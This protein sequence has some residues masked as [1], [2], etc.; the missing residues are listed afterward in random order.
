MTNDDLAGMVETSDEWIRQR[1][2]IRERRRADPGT[3]TS[4]LAIAAGRAA[5]ERRGMDGSDLDLIIVATMT[6]DRPFPSTACVV[7]HGLGASSAWAFDVSAAC[8][9][10]VYAATVAAQFIE[11]G[12]HRRVLVIGAEVMSSVVDYT[13]RTTCVLFGDGAGAVLM[14]PSQ[15]ETGILSFCHEVDGAGAPF[16]CMPAGGSATPASH[17]T[18]EKGWH[19]LRQDGP[20]VF[21]FATRKMAELSQ[22]VVAEAGLTADDIDL[23]VPHQANARII[24]AVAER[25]RLPE[26]KVVKNL[27]RLGNTSAASIPLALTTAVRQGRLSRGSLVLLASVG[28]GFTVGTML[29]RW[30]G[31]QATHWEAAAQ[32]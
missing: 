4:A 2:G 30:S 11:N 28:A 25:L 15:D 14:E 22:R 6:P 9:G 1:T 20:E 5:L 10:F 31:A 7:Q 21:R 8:S 29:L 17:E 13:D 12:S 27:E 18:V 3:P 26:H 16:L 19:F 24:D 23:F 32:A